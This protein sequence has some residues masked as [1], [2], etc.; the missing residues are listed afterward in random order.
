M[1]LQHVNN[2]LDSLQIVFFVQET[3]IDEP[4]KVFINGGHW[5][6]NGNINNRVRNDQ[7][8]DIIDYNI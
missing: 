3:L 6:L 2:R 7:R 1:L 4:F 5:E 8:T